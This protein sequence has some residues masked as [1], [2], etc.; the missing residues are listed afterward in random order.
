M[1]PSTDAAA[2][3]RAK[4]GDARA[5]AEQMKDPQARSTMFKIA[6]GYEH[7]AEISERAMTRSR[8]Q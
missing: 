2:V 8:N 7:I 4:A 5:Q 1:P 3:W 6:E